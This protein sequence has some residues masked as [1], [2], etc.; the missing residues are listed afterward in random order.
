M[1]V[2]TVVPGTK[3]IPHK[4][5]IQERSKF[6]AYI[7][8]TVVVILVEPA[9][10]NFY[11]CAWCGIFFSPACLCM[12]HSAPTPSERFRAQCSMGQASDVHIQ[13]HGYHMNCKAKLSSLTYLR[14]V[15]ELRPK[16]SP[17]YAIVVYLN[18]ITPNFIAFNN[19]QTE[20][21]KGQNTSSLFISPTSS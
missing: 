9:H 10:I 17:D 21:M 3:K 20:T 1:L 7:I 15:L 11:S 2:C 18:K 5:F 16:G 8:Y 12:Y 14:D 13:D 19:S 6:C 4:K